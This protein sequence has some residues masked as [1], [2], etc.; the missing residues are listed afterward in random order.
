MFK[1]LLRIIAI[2]LFIGILLFYFKPL[3]LFENND[4]ER[5]MAKNEIV[6][7][8]R[9]GPTTYYEIKGKNNGYGYDLMKGFADFLNVNLKIVIRKVM[10]G[11][12]PQ[13]ETHIRQGRRAHKVNGS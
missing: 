5:I 13:D 10:Q 9:I 2:S 12:H 8:T 3:S 4:Y 1:F 11:K 7:A 6:F